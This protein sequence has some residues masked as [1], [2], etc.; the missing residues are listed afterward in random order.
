MH[1]EATNWRPLLL[2]SLCSARLQLKTQRTVIAQTDED[3][4]LEDDALKAE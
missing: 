3:D 4:T 2:H 1:E